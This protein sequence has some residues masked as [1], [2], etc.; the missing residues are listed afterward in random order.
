M[1]VLENEW[2]N[3]MAGR[4]HYS[5]FIASWMLVGGRTDDNFRMF[6]K[7]LKQLEFLSENDIDNILFLARNGKAELQ[8]D[9]ADFIRST[10]D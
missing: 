1:I 10:S 2:E 7:W 6:E 4:I 5:R 3:K 8:D 9:A